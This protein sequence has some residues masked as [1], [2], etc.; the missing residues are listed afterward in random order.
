[1]KIETYITGGEYI[2]R[3]KSISGDGTGVCEAGG[4]IIFAR[5]VLPGECARVRLTD[6]R[7]SYAKAELVEL[8]ERSADRIR[9]VCGYFGKC[10]GCDLMHVPYEKELIYKRRF[11]A[12]AFRRIAG[13]S[14]VVVEPVAGDWNG[15]QTAFSY[16]Y[17]NKG[18][19][20]YSN[21]GF[22][23]YKAGTHDVVAINDCLL[24]KK[25]NAHILSIISEWASDCKVAGL[26]LSDVVI[27]TGEAT[28]DVLIVMNYDSADGA[29]INHVTQSLN[30]LKLQGLAADLERRVPGLRSVVA[31][32]GNESAPNRAGS[33]HGGAEN[34]RGNAGG[35]RV[36]AGGGRDRTRNGRDRTGS[37]RGGAGKRTYIL[38]G[39]GAIE[40]KIGQYKFRVTH[41]A[42]FQV[43]TNAAKTLFATILE[44]ARAGSEDSVVDFF[45]GTGAISTFLSRHVKN[46]TG[47]DS[48]ASAIKDALTN[49]KNNGLANLTFT[50]ERAEQAAASLIRGG[51][52]PDLIILD[53]PRR[54]CGEGLISAIKE[55]GAERI[56][57]VSCDPATLC[58]DVARLTAGG[59]VG[60]NSS[61]SDNGGNRGVVGAAGYAGYALASVRPV[62]MF[63]RTANIETVALLVRK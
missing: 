8:L 2:V 16:R 6:V 22:G 11:L 20:K 51:A 48:S 23:F 5:G 41:D 31:R 44:L 25:Q 43:N 1:M 63:P 40:E 47:V 37:G 13:M 24:Q 29:E 18:S 62:D 45:C 14:G 55:L 46:V 42:F 33:G 61:N 9:P 49:A 28:G 10:G 3:A 57:Y 39:E 26:T 54:G 30:L 27:R 35:G 53:P 12:G 17:R 58:R 56:V 21:E 60:G 38:S 34:E 7:S 4:F 52:K 32:I 15:E 50:E 19:Y 36:G 59:A